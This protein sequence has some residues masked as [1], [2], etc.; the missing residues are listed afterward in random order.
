MAKF[1][2][3]LRFLSFQRQAVGGF[4]PTSPLVIA[5]RRA[6]RFQHEDGENDEARGDDGDSGQV[7]CDRVVA[8]I[9][10]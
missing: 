8:R 5:E 2:K 3:A 1:N 4:W 10:M 7:K 9:V 6:F